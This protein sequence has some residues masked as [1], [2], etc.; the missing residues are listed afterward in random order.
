MDETKPYIDDE[1][2]LVELLQTIW[3]G[4]WAILGIIATSVAGVLGYQAVSP[5]PSFVATTEIK[6]ISSVESERYRE[7]NAVGFFE[8]QPQTLLNLYLEQ[9]DQRILFQ[10]AL[11]EFD[12]LKRDDFESDEKFEEA[13]VALAASIEL[14]PPLNV[15]GTERGESRKHW[16]VVFEHHDQQAWLAALSSV[17][18][19]ASEEVR[20]SLH[21]RFG[22]ALS[23]AKTKREFELEDLNTQISNLKNDYERN[24]SDRLAYLREQA[25]IARKL[26]VANNTIEAQTF[27]TQNGMVANVNTDT[28]FYLRGY[29]A[30]EKEIELIESRS[31]KSAF[32]KGLLEVEQKI[33]ALNQDK[34]LERAESLFG[35]TPI[36]QEEPFS[37]VSMAAAAT[38]FEFKNRQ[39]L[40]IALAVVV[41]GMF[42]AL[43]VLIRSAVRKRASHA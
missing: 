11:K 20:R 36:A 32:I 27:S 8:V 38:E 10:E 4:R 26:G 22:L 30:I 25:N 34:T 37:A 43:F 35:A 42:G 18:Q 24:T 16:G 31:N 7:S 21:R 9:L 6:P 15:D 13:A 19:F 17:H 3:D 14:S 23:V 28:P 2:D 41:G 5:P 33:R 39:M 1:I 12:L 29:T 40:M